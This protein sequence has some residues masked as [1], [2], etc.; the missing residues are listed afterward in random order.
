M[1]GMA[2]LY[3]PRGIDLVVRSGALQPKPAGPQLKPGA[4]AGGVKAPNYLAAGRG[5]WG[6]P[7]PLTGMQRWN[8]AW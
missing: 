2:A 6:E 4:G 3:R 5:C 1:H 8:C 7:R